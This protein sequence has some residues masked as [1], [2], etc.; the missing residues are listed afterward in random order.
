MLLEFYDKLQRSYL[1]SENWFQK[2]SLQSWYI[3]FL[4]W[5]G[6]R[7]CSALPEGLTGFQRVIPSHLFYPCLEEALTKV[8]DDRKK[9]LRWIEEDEAEIEE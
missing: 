7:Q 9:N 8:D 3:D 1:C 4:K 6:A 2:Y 5:V